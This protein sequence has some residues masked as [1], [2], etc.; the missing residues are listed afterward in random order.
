[1][2]VKKVKTSLG[3]SNV[4]TIKE[5]LPR[6]VLNKMRTNIWKE[7]YIAKT[8]F[9]QNLGIVRSKFLLL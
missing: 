9:N 8:K 2:T 6:S 5:F 4:Y 1:M 3:P 7:S